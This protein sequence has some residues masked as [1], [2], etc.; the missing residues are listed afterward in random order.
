MMRTHTRLIFTLLFSFIFFPN[1]VYATD[2]TQYS[3]LVCEM[4]DVSSKQILDLASQRAA[5]KKDIEAIVLCSVVASR[6]RDDMNAEERNL[7][8][9]AHLKAGDIYNAQ[10]NYSAAL[11]EYIEGVKISESCSKPIYA[12]RLYNKIGNIYCIFLDYP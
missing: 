9:L 12:A 4:Q 10:S 1:E 3:D 8:T 6:F 5:E 2:W 7:C 11:S